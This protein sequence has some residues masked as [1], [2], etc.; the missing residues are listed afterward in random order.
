MT[1]ILDR[2]RPTRDDGAPPPIRSVRL[3]RWTVVAV[4]A[5]LLVAVPVVVAAWP[6][7][8]AVSVSPSELRDRVA[9]SQDLPWSGYAEAT[10]GLNLPDVAQFSDVT[11][12]LSGTSRLRGWYAAPDRVR[13]DQ[14]YPGGER[15]RYT[16]GTG[17]VVWDYGAQLLTYVR[18]DPLVRLP[19]PDDLLPPQLARRLLSGTLPDDPVAALPARR[20]AGVDA[21]GF[22]VTVADPRTTVGAL[23]VW[24]DPTDGL[25]VAVEVRTKNA[26][27]ALASGPAV[28][29]R[30]LELDRTTPDPALFVA[31]QTPGV[32]VT[33]SPTSDLFGVL[34]RGSP[35][36]V[37]GTVDGVDR[38]APQRGFAAIGKYGTTLSQLIVVPLPAD[39]AGSLLGNI[40]DA[41]SAGRTITVTAPQNALGR[42]ANASAGALESSLLRLAV[43]RV[44]NRAWAVGGLVTDDVLDRA[45]ADIAADSA[46]A[47]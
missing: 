29:T 42:T 4:V 21:A 7:S 37:P 47:P 39:I 22:R 16:T 24:A 34:G 9:A 32:G 12:L 33:R 1:A 30:F 11:S 28:G 23:D 36:A 18:R 40:G 35:D 19:R 20:V 8:P 25:P 13:V 15:S 27:G 31:A 14:L 43:L 45:V 10:G 17:Q 5:A 41:G 26:S 38:V 46:G 3:R 2:L 44:G 6:V